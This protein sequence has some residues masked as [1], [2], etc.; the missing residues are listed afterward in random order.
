MKQ[1]YFLLIFALV[2]F[3]KSS[4]L[5][6]QNIEKRDRKFWEDTGQRIRERE[7][8]KHENEELE[9]NE[10]EIEENDNEENDPQ[11]FKDYS[12]EDDNLIQRS[13]SKIPFEEYYRL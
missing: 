11:A 5:Q 9:N 1:L 10:R 3:S 2:I 8:E 12:F 4:L 6:G 13:R 7:N